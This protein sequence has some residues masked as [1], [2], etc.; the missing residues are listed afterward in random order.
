MSSSLQAARPRLRALGFGL[1]RL[2]VHCWK[3]PVPS[4]G[5]LKDRVQTSFRIPECGNHT[6]TKNDV[7]IVLQAADFVVSYVAEFLPVQVI[8]CDTKAFLP[9][10]ASTLAVRKQGSDVD[11]I[12]SFDVL[13]RVRCTQVAPWKQFNKEEMA[14][15]V[16]LTG[17]THLG[18]TGTTV[19]ATLIHARSVMQAARLVGARVGSC[20]I[21]AFL[22]YRP[23][24]LSQNGS[25]RFGFVA[26]EASTLIK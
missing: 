14:M 10:A 17:A 8:S 5:E 26:Y 22:F 12:G 18:I 23:L 6:L 15:D 2:F 16:K 7:Q 13:T 3:I 11:Y 19:R 9:T 21:V 24:G 25:D 4:D 1:D 20:K